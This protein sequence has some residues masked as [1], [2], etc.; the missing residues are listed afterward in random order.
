VVTAL[1]EAKVDEL[2]AE[3]LRIGTERWRAKLKTCKSSLPTSHPLL[4]SHDQ[5]CPVDVDSTM[6]PFKFRTKNC[7]HAAFKDG[8]KK[9][10][11]V[12]QFLFLIMVQTK[13]SLQS[14]EY[15]LTKD[16]VIADNVN[17]GPLSVD[18]DD[19]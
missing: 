15:L 8:P 19:E 11:W 7:A 2:S 14:S 13:Y 3:Q 18:F 12:P 5:A 1:Y 4:H 16:R 10:R 17:Q 9:I 6:V